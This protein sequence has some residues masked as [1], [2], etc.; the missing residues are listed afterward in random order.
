MLI[1]SVTLASRWFTFSSSAS[2]LAAS[3]LNPAIKPL[4]NLLHFL[5]NQCKPCAVS[6]SLSCIALYKASLTPSH[7]VWCHI[8]HMSHF[9]PCSLR[10]TSLSLLPQLKS[11][12]LAL[13]VLVEP[14]L[15]RS[16]L[17]VSDKDSLRLSKLTV[18]LLHQ[19]STLISYTLTKSNPLN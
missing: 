11:S 4:A 8:S 5:Q 16:E 10:A 17:M 1:F 9:R 15:F 7:A 12:F 3:L 19:V 14:G 6:C 18:P 2:Y 13:L